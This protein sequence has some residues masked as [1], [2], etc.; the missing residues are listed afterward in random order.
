MR[1][2]FWVLG[3]IGLAIALTCLFWKARFAATDAHFMLLSE[4]A[5]IPSRPYTFTCSWWISGFLN[6]PAVSFEISASF[7]NVVLYALIFYLLIGSGFSLA[8]LKIREKSPAR[9]AK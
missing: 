9:N 7:A 4:F 8:L 1:H 6:S 2:L 3:G 5:V